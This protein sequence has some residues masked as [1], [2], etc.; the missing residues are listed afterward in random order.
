MSIF[1]L[2][3]PK[4]KQQAAIIEINNSFS[5]FSGSAYS[6]AAFRAA[7]DAISRHAAKLTAHSDDKNLENLLTQS[8]NSYMSAYDMLYK[9][10]TSY[11]STITLLS[12]LTVTDTALKTCTRSRRQ[13]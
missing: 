2:F 11:L 3:K 9:I 7:V 12:Y 6:N 5:S 8:P 1:N 13:A 4:Q 10:T